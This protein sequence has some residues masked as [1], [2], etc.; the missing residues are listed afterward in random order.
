MQGLSGLEVKASPI[1][2]KG[3]FATKAFRPGEILMDL[4]RP[5]LALPES[6]RAHDT[7]AWCF[8]WTSMPN[9]FSEATENMFE[10]VAQR[11]NHSWCTG[12]KKV[13]SKYAVRLV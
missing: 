7:C 6:E 1:A 11:K 3:L 8:N 2:G 10:E 13:G 9:L 12:C 5:L 4:E